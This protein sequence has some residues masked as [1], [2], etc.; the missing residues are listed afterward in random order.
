MR[1]MSKIKKVLF[2]CYANICRSPAAEELAKVYAKKQGLSNIEF[3]SAG[4]HTAFPTAVK[5]T[6][7]YLNSKGIDAT[8]FVSKLITK[9][10][11]E[12][13]DLVIGMEK[14][15][16]M[17][18][19]RKFKD[20]K[21]TLKGKLFTLKEFNGADKQNINIPDPYDTGDENYRRIMKIV[22]DEV[23]K[24]IIKIKNLNE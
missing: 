19:R 16:L 23:E 5:E 7:D 13:S 8:N 11:I 3:D 22:D 17:K 15:H 1:K 24:L 6:K 18:V 12:N 20:I 21:D 14:Y 2:I 4:W 9:D 10:L